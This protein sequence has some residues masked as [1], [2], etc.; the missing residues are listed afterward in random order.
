MRRVSRL[1]EALG[2]RRL[3]LCDVW[4]VLHD[5][6]AHFPEAAAAL[7]RAR[8]LGRHVLLVSNAPRPAASVR[9]QLR[10]LGVPDGAY[11]A[12]LTSGDL[13]RALVAR[14]APERFLHLGPPRDAPL[15]E[16]VGAPVLAVEAAQYVL[17]S[18]LDDDATETPDDY[19]ARFRVFL[20]AGLPM[21]CAN[22]DLTVDRGGRTIWCAGAL[23]ERYAAMGGAVEGIGKPHPQIYAEAL[24][25]ASEAIGAPIAAADAFAIGDSFRTDIAGAA[26]AGIASLVVEAGVHAADLEATEDRAEA[27]E[28]LARRW[29]ARPDFVMETLR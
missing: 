2:D 25:L 11:D 9:A 5:G 14:R 8:A 10:G 3:V 6:V 1:E 16:G 23:A 17:C 28:G 24:R 12:I 27:L 7:A 18:G 19:E 29:G 20:A 21:L 4:G 22:P 15:F 26:G 13:V